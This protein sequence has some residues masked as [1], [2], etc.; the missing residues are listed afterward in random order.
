MKKKYHKQP[1]SQFPFL[2]Y[3]NQ[4]GTIGH[5]PKRKEIMFC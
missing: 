1:L 3:K 4:K 5:I 2:N